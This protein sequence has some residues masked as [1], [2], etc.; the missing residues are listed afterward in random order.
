MPNSF[1]EKW[2]KLLEAQHVQTIETL[3]WTPWSEPE[4]TTTFGGR[5]SSMPEVMAWLRRVYA[6][7]AVVESYGSTEVGSIAR[8]HRRRGRP[9]T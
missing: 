3:P 1:W 7:C 6:Q 2:S 4:P 5:F 8:S 9:A